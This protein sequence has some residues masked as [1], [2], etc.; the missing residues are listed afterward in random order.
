MAVI[1]DLDKLDATVL[2]DDGDGGGVSI[3]AA[4]D[5]LFDGDTGR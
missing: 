2:N 5:Q 3:E 1:G 4:L